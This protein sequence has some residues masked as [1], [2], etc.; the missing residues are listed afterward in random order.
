MMLVLVTGG[1]GSGKSEFAENTAVKMGGSLTYIAAMKPY[2]D[3]CIR[4]I[5]R[6][7]AMREGKGF[8]TIEC[9]TG[10]KNLNIRGTALLECMSN[11]TANEMYSEN[12]SGD[13]AVDEILSGVE[14]L[15][16][17]CDNLIIVTNEIASDG[18]DYDGDTKT[19]MRNL[20]RINCEIAKNAD[21]VYEVACGVPF[22]LKQNVKRRTR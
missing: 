5:E 21:V 4:R 19:Y 14:H 1:S 12:G 7:R 10:I 20:G 9:Y 6:H 2:D 17:C 15:A 11:L 22:R 18:I 13:R 8:N 3:E 16:A